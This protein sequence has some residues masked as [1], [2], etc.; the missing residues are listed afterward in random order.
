MDKVIYIK[1]KEISE[2]EISLYRNHS[3]HT[4][5]GKIQIKTLFDKIKN[6]NTYKILNGQCINIQTI[7]DIYRKYGH[8][9]SEY[10]NIKSYIPCVTPSGVFTYADNNSL[11]LPS[12]LLVLD[13]DDLYNVDI[14]K[15][16]INK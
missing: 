14:D 2:K 15:I 11:I 4:P 5:I 1:G 8:Q 6:S 3:D 7:R 16:K 9:S 10:K 12:N 13:I